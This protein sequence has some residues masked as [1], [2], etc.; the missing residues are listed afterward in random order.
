MIPR[1]RAAR[2]T[3]RSMAL[4]TELQEGEAVLV[5]A[6]LTHEFRAAPGE[7]AEV[8]LVMFGEGV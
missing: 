7:C 8:T 3:R 1:R 2:P 5:P 4:C 6:G